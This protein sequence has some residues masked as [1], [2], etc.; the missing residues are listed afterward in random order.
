[1][2]SILCLYIRVLVLKDAASASIYGARASF[3]VI[4]ITTKKGSAGKTNINYSANVR[5]SKATQVPE[6]MDSYQFAR[7]FNAA[8]ANAG[9]SPVFSAE[10]MQ[11]IQDYQAGKLTDG[12][13]PS[14]DGKTWNNYTGANANTDWFAENYK[15]WVPSQQH[16]LSISGGNERLTY[17]VSGSFMNQNGLIRH[18]KDEFNRYT[19]D[20][21]ISAKITDWLTLNYTNKWT[22]ED[23]QRPTYMTGLFFHNIARRWPTNPVYDNNGFLMEG[24]EVIQM[25]DGGVQSK[26]KNY[27]TQQVGLVFEPIKDWHINIEGNMRTYTHREHWEVLPVYAHRP[28]GEPFPFSWDGGA[29]YAPGQTRVNE[30]R[31]TDDYFT[32]NIYSDYSKTI[33]DHYFKVMAGFN[34]EL[35]KTDQIS[36][37]G[38]ALIDATTPWLDQTTA[39]KRAYGGRN[40]TSLAGFFGRINYVY[41]DRYM[42]EV[43]GRYDGSS[44]FVGSKRWGFFPSFSLGWNIAREEFFQNW[45]DK[46]G[47]LKLR[48]SWGQLG[49]SN[50]KDW[51]PFYQTMSTGTANSQWLV[52]GKRQNTA[53]MPGMISTAMTWETVESWDV[54]LDW[55]AFRNRLTGSF[56]F[57]QRTTKDMVGPAPEL[58]NALGTGVPRI[59]NCDMRSTGWELE[60]GWRDQIKEVSYG[61]KMVLSDATDKILKFPNEDKLLDNYYDGEKL[62]NIWGYETA[63]IAQSQEQM[64]E[65]LALNKPTWGSNWNAGDIMYKDLTGDKIVNNGKN[66]LEDHGD[67]KILGNTTPR[68]NIGLNLDAAWRG[69]D[70]SMFWQGTLK[71]DYWLDGPYFWGATGGMWQSAGFKEHW[72]F[73]RPEGDALGANTDAYFPRANFDGGKNQKVQSRFVQNAAYIRLKN[74]QIGYTLPQ[75]WVSKAGMNNVRIYI[76]GDNLLT[77][78][79][80]TGVFDPEALGG[81]W[82]EGKLYPLQKTISVGLNVN[83]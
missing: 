74:L 18:G 48:G 78:S 55:G 14:S 71:R 27:Y 43:N 83:F 6:M 45:T 44:R 51:Y 46:I 80:I 54:G 65:H 73:W 26:Q 20:S 39:L 30:Y 35:T 29:S 37:Q 2:K 53:V 7:Y 58:P 15:D 59:N 60:I 4:M 47:T 12:T 50:T 5:F 67:L 3:G 33:G 75:A 13:V 17:R 42:V 19:V 40:H 34:A 69:F 21:K 63:G 66:T 32:T 11:R 8:A 25:E 79:D 52:N 38:D 41:K 28:N 36:A 24:N 22:R 57:Y 56:D 31:Y 16:N 23:Y 49:N 76:S 81:S 9:Q 64:N 82:G 72:D 1:M 10:V 70:I 61:V 62:G 77:I 68:Y